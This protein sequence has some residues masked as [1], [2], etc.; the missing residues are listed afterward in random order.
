M[1]ISSQRVN[2]GDDLLGAYLHQIGRYPLLDRESEVELGKLIERGQPSLKKLT[3]GHEWISSSERQLIDAA[4]DARQ[5]FVEANLRLVVMLARRFTTNELELLDV[6]Q[7]GNVGLVRAVDKW[8]WRLGYKFSTY[9][10]WWIRQAIGVGTEQTS[11]TIRIPRRIRENLSEIRARANGA[12]N[13]CPHKGQGKSWLEMSRSD[14]QLILNLWQPLISLDAPITD[15]GTTVSDF[16][17]VAASRSLS[18]INSEDGIVHEL[19]AGVRDLPDE[20]QIVICGLYGLNGGKRESKLSLAR[21]LGISEGRVTELSQA[22][23][24][25]LR[26]FLIDV[27]VT[28]AS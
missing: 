10:T 25:L 23:I 21:R 24:T 28:R 19:E 22:G 11:R 1:G 4:I 26:E 3:A 16:I 7:L 17:A 12:E 2:S 18:E 14:A 20:L 5:R 15:D 6:I 13:T 27:P 8:D 9:A